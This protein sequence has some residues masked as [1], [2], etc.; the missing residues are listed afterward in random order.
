[1]SSNKMT[2]LAGAL[3]LAAAALLAG[4]GSGS[5]PEAHPANAPQKAAVRVTVT[6][7]A[8]E[9]WP[10]GVELTGTVRARTT[11]DVAARAMGYIRELRPQTGDRVS[12]GQVI[13]IIDSRDLDAGVKQAEAAETEARSA[14]AEVET[15]GRAA[16]AQLDLAK[17]THE[18]MRTL[19][20]KNSISKQEMDEADMRLRVAE[21]GVEAVA[22]KRKQLDAKIAQAQEGVRL[23]KVNLGF[24]EVR[25]PFAGVVIARKAEPGT[26]ASP[27]LP[28]VTLERAGAFRAEITVDE[29]KIRDIKAGSTAAL[30]IEALDQNITARVT[31]VVPA[32]QADS[33][34]FVV[35][36]DLPASANLRSGLFV[37]ARF[38][39][40]TRQVLA[41]DAAA[42]KADGQLQSV[43]V[44]DN[45]VAH[46]RMVR[47]GDKQQGKVE[48]LSGLQE[49]DLIIAPASGAKDGDRVEVRQ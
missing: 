34:G 30:T 21:S 37:R 7:A 20:Q 39:T 49:G 1:M 14:I 2:L 25:A 6:K 35:K 48:I 12:E 18:R 13:A 36:L 43:L 32:V 24:A 4:C 42:V 9:T 28:L 10:A 22:S 45:G 31:E 41:A 3:G 38:D 8:K 44:A 46:E 40:G 15:A 16:K 5:K 19:F 11:T 47:T 26:L 17:V 27:G 33:R 29:S 23:A